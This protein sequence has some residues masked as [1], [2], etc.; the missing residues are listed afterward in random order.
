MG[1]A[2]LTPPGLPWLQVDEGTITSALGCCL[3]ASH[4]LD[5]DEKL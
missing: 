3:E 5:V 1:A 2:P 4:M